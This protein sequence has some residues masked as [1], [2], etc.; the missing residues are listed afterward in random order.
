MLLASSR[1]N[2]QNEY[3]LFLKN[4]AQVI[5]NEQVRNDYLIH[6]YIDCA[7]KKQAFFEDLQESKRFNPQQNPK[8]LIDI[9]AQI[10]K[11]RKD[12]L[13]EKN[14]LQKVYYQ[15]HFLFDFGNIEEFILLFENHENNTNFYFDYLKVATIYLHIGDI[16][17]A[18]N[19][20]QK[21]IQDA[22]DS[23]P[24]EPYLNEQFLPILEQF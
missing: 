10:T 1:L 24:F 16:L 23:R 11:H 12:L 9:E 22:M 20:I 13:K 2:N 5:D 3:V 8:N 21:Y 17:K 6:K 15:L 18:K 14:A 7:E 19:Y 4:I